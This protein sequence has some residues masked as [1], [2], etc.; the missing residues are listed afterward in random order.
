MRP[1][2]RGRGG[3]GAVYGL[4]RL[5]DWVAVRNVQM[6]VEHWLLSELLVGT[7]L[8]QLAAIGAGLVVAYFAARPLDA[9]LRKAAAKTAGV[10]RTL[11]LVVRLARSLAFPI[12]ALVL[13][14]IALFA[15]MRL[16]W[17][18]L[19]LQTAASLVGVWIVIRLTS[20]L[21]RNETMG[22]LIAVAAFTV[23]TL[24]VLDLLQPTLVVLDQLGFAVGTVRVSVLSVL[25][26]LV[27][28]AA[29]LWLATTLA[30]LIEQR[31]YRARTLTPSI[32]VLTAKLLRAGAIAAAVVIGLGLV[33][34]D[35]TAFAVF[36]GAL[37]VGIGFGL[38]KPI[39]NLISGIILLLD[40]SIK[41]GDVIE[42]G[43][44][45]GWISS[46]NARYATVTT[47]D[48]T[49]WLIPNEDLIT[50]RVINWS[51][52]D[53]RL[54]LSTPIGISYRSDVRKAIAL[55]VDAAKE[56]ARVMKD[57]PPVC[58]LMG[59]GDSSVDLEMRIWI[60]DPTNGV[61]N[62]RSEVLLGVWDRFRAHGIEIPFPQR[63]LHVRPGSTIE[64]ALA[65]RHPEPAASR[66]AEA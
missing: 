25:K 41:P 45:F 65:P 52:T 18:A 36:T 32:K 61:I 33:G 34:I 6:A 19:V 15:A 17:P 43:N 8:L 1:G 7:T 31:L 26:G 59:F 9:Q 40:R 22:R 2:A 54:R 42:I 16:G 5:I 30:R 39:S 35:L 57:P 62:V 14:C 63:D 23:A 13:L 55:V 38:Q 46:L 48:G 11:G 44:T 60:S 50:Q 21:I 47:R 56:N 64:V 49:E 27:A 10:E 66:P 3:A 28:F 37:G 51:Y 12:L 20:A 4:E 58:R 24:N 53:Q 29:L